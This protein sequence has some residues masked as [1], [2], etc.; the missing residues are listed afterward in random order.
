MAEE[1]GMSV[2]AWK[3]ARASLMV[4][5]FRYAMGGPFFMCLPGVP[6][7]E[8]I[9]SDKVS[10]IKPDKMVAKDLVKAWRES[11]AGKASVAPGLFTQVEWVAER[12]LVPFKDV[13]V[14]EVP[15]CS[16]VSL[17]LWAKA[18]EAD[19]RQMYD[20][21]RMERA[22]ASRPTRPEKRAMTEEREAIDRLLRKGDKGSR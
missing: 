15:C 6:H 2:T 10:F 7:G 9:A 22:K 1:I 8:V 18:N 19:F 16:A 14:E 20:A 13:T 4:E 3:H 12:L 21:K 11:K 17:L 5:S